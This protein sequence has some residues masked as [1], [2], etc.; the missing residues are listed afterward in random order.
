MIIEDLIGSG[1]GIGVREVQLLKSEC[2]Q[3]LNEAA[4][5]PLLKPLPAT[6][7]NFHKV[8][9]RL[10]K[11]K[12][13]VT[14]V[15]EQAFGQTFVNLR[16]RAVFAYPSPQPLTEGF[17]QFYVFPVNG[18]KHMYSK[19]ITNSS[20][21]Y[22]RVVDTVFQQFEDQQQASEIVSDLLKY[23]YSGASLQEG[24]VSDSEIILYGIPY[25]YAVRASACQGYTALLNLAK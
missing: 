2:S 16:Q 3:F 19:E 1:I 13:S 18:Y 7:Y 11:R 15:F 22:K 25:Y 14:D 9:V 10:Q 5:L 6:Y 4:S 17:D 24:I 23:T 20:N 21:D 12:D 8:K